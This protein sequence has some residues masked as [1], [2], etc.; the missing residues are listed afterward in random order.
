ML[1]T[2]GIFT[3]KTTWQYIRHKEK[4]NKIYKCIWVKGLLFKVAFLMR[5][6]WKLKIPMDDRFKRWGMEGL[7]KCWC[8]ENPSQE[9]MNHVF[10]RS[11]IANRIWSY[12][13][14]FAGLN[15]EGL[16]L[17][18][19]IMLWWEA[20]VKNSLQPYYRV[21]PNL[22]VWELWRRRNNNKH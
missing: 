9:T 10:L 6:L 7:S 15:S 5:R 14:S 4:E 20:E 12:F 19:V 13:S 1:D 2:K 22:I 3:V 8:W 11:N 21:L 17:R 16:S 18:E